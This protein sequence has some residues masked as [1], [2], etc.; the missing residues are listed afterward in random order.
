M[1]FQTFNWVGYE[2]AFDDLVGL[3]FTVRVPRRGT[4]VSVE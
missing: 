1:R 2:K 4:G 3:R